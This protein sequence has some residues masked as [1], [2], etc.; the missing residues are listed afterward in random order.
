MNRF[1]KYILLF[2][3]LKSFEILAQ[4]ENNN[5]PKKSNSN[6]TQVFRKKIQNLSE[7][8]QD[9]I[10]KTEL[11]LMYEKVKDEGIRG[12][13]K[14]DMLKIAAISAGV[15]GYGILD[16]KL[17]ISMNLYKAISKKLSSSAKFLS[18]NKKNTA[19]VLIGTAA[20]IITAK[21][22]YNWIKPKNQSRKYSDILDSFLST[23]HEDQRAIILNS[24]ELM[25][26]LSRSSKSPKVLL[27]KS[28]YEL[29]DKDQQKNLDY[30]V[31][32]F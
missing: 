31:S 17:G 6:I 10:I 2:L 8:A 18:E 1:A 30:L 19:L 20:S 29:L 5:L 26:L 27:N 13:D 15:I 3:A 14:K 21:L 9:I 28:F 4:N 23:L 24:E 11:P 12:L 7:R 22:I 16:Y 25:Q 32:S